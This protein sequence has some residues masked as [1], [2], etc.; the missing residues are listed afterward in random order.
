MRGLH[1]NIHRSAFT[2]IELLVVIAIIAILAAILFPVFAAAKE[3]AKR[4]ACLSNTKQV[5]T[6]LVIYVNDYD[7][8][9]PSLFEVPPA[10]ETAV[11][12]ESEDVFQVLQPYVKNM[13][14]FYCPDRS[15]TSPACSIATFPGLY[16]AP[17]TSQRCLG[18]G[19]NWGFIPEAGGGLFSTE[20]PSADGQYLVD[21]GISTTS[22]DSPAS[23]AVWGDTTNAARFKMS[24]LAS[25]L[26]ENILG[27]S[28]SVQHN[29]LMRHGGM[30]N[31]SFLDGHSKNVPF[32]GGTLANTP[33]GIIYVGVP[34]NDTLRSMYCLTSDAP[35]NIS[36]LASGS[37]YPTLIPCSQALFL[38]DEFG[39]QW[40][41][42]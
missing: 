22:A 9:T 35:V 36:L 24:A 23:F 33:V 28:P 13:D 39:I 30:F 42:D 10:S 16:G 27:T 18:L 12:P 40:W 19:Y 3:A 1:S 20:V 2:L 29:S 32:K 15:D 25:I 31:I 8:T 11:S 38:P 21:V 37:G 5:G 41:P 6:G 26:D 17:Q 14:V 7:D 34:K 4:S